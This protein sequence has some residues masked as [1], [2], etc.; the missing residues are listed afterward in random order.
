MKLTDGAELSFSFC[1]K[2]EDI[3]TYGIE[4][5]GIVYVKD[6]KY[7]TVVDDDKNPGSKFYDVSDTPGGVILW[8]DDKKQAVWSGDGFKSFKIVKV[9]QLTLDDRS[10]YVNR[11]LTVNEDPQFKKYFNYDK[12]NGKL[13]TTDL[14]SGEWTEVDMDLL[15]PTIIKYINQDYFLRV[16]DTSDGNGGNY[17]TN[18]TLFLLDRV[19][20]DKSDSLFSMYDM[21]YYYGQDWNM[22]GTSSGSGSLS[23]IDT[24]YT[25]FINMLNSNS[26]VAGRRYRF[27]YSPVTVPNESA[28]MKESGYWKYN[29]TVTATGQNTYDHKVTVSKPDDVTDTQW[30]KH[31][32]IPASR[33][34]DVNAWWQTSIYSNLIGQGYI[35]TTGFVYK[36]EYNNSVYLNMDI[37]GSNR[38]NSTDSP[39][40]SYISNC[41]KV[42]ITGD[43]IKANDIKN[44]RYETS[45]SVNIPSNSV[46]N[47]I[48]AYSYSVYSLNY[49][50]M[51]YTTTIENI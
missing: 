31:M 3:I 45:T 33:L 37:I 7:L 42:R 35:A 38:Y 43:N 40:S 26:L 39:N 48:N 17:D 41:Y 18:S 16:P 27:L 9:N 6:Q 25:E 28:S 21:Y 47:G 34:D 49:E 11:R 1:D 30:N 23:V 36:I 13:Y 46:A 14:D 8:D 20:V 24:T 12:E 44:D 19:N 4:P 29:I 22:V 51:A 2:E 15:S 50:Y 10:V 5:G 32:M